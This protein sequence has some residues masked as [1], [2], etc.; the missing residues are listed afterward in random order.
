MGG[1]SCE[2]IS[3]L[4]ARKAIHWGRYEQW[5]AQLPRK[6]WCLTSPITEKLKRYSVCPSP[7]RMVWAQNNWHNAK[8]IAER[9]TTLAK[10]Q[11]LQPEKRKATVQTLLG[12]ALVTAQRHILLNKLVMKWLNPCRNK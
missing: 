5:Q 6:H 4:Y 11:K 2:A 8:A 3:Q 9:I 10:D 12:R 1:K 7:L